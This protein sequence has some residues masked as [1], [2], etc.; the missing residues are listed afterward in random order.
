MNFVMIIYAVLFGIILGS[1]SSFVPRCHAQAIESSAVNVRL[2][3]D[4][5]DAVLAIF[6]KK[7]A[8]QSI[9]DADWQRLFSSEGYVRL[10]KREAE[11]QRSF[12]DAEFKSF[13]LSDSLAERAQALDETL[14]KW[15][16]AEVNR[17]AQLAL[18]YL[19]PGARIRAKIYPMIKPKANSFVFEVNTDPAIFLYLDILENRLTGEEEIR[20]VGFSFFGLQGPR[21]TVGWKMAVTIEKAYGRAKL[22]ECFCDQSKLLATYNRA[23]AE[24]NR[25][26]AAPLALWSSSLI[27]GISKA[28]S[29]K[30][31]P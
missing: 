1:A 14:S 19:P 20:Q 24:Y 26:T 15:K 29:R 22:I 13:V 28:G 4:E 8:H 12:A 30:S 16:R 5:A 18:A 7:R 6:A 2:V 31:S 27:E 25:S 3:T 21:Y 17:A 9:M 11:M 10:K 23:A